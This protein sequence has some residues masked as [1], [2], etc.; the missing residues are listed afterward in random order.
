M[1]DA[2]VLNDVAFSLPNLSITR[3]ISTTTRA[4]TVIDDDG[5]TEVL[6]EMDDG[7]GYLATKECA[8]CG[9]GLYTFQEAAT[10]AGVF[11]AADPFTC[12]SCPDEHMSFDSLGQC[13]CDDGWVKSG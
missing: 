4:V 7:G 10:E 1:Q 8:S 3:P 13:D 9:D 12:Q 5:F 6:L 2:I 11:Y